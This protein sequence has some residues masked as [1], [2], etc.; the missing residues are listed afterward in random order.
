MT[1]PGRR[2]PA[3]SASLDRVRLSGSRV[4]RGCPACGKW[5]SGEK[6]LPAGRGG[7][8]PVLGKASIAPDLRADELQAA[9]A[10]LVAR[11]LHGAGAVYA[12]RE[13]LA[14][15]LR[16]AS[17]E[18]ETAAQRGVAV[19]RLVVEGLAEP[20]AAL[21][22]FP[23]GVEVSGDERAFVV[24]LWLAPEPQGPD[25]A[26]VLRALGAGKTL[27]LLRTAD[28]VEAVLDALAGAA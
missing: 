3:C 24:V 12:R 17:L 21:G 1:A 4:E 14:Q 20:R 25:L 27:H 15:A 8:W 23:Q 5:F 10:Q 13:E 18:V 7:R 16:D 22:V 6:A 2:C 11:A 28:N 19:L 9:A 26:G